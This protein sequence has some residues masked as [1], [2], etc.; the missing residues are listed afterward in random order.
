M[1]KYLKQKINPEDIIE[2]RLAKQLELKQGR[3]QLRAA[4]VSTTGQLNEKMVRDLPVDRIS[5]P[6]QQLKTGADFQ[7]DQLARQARKEAIQQTSGSLDYNQL[8]KEFADKMKGVA[9]VG[10]KKLLGAI[11]VLGGIAQAVSSQDASAAVPFL[12]DSD[13]LGPS[14]GSLDERIEKGTLTDA[15]REMLQEQQIRLQALQKLR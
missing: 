12:G 15:D 8:R 7:A 14:A 11:P 10:G 13:S 5:N 6:V 2:E 3:E 4:P 1:D 9:K